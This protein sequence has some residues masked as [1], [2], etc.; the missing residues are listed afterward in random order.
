MKSTALNWLFPLA[1]ML[2]GCATLISSDEQSV[3]VTTNCQSRKIS[4]ICVA[5]NDKGTWRFETP[6]QVV[7]KKS[8]SNLMITCQGGLLGDS[9]QFSTSVLGLPIFGN[10]LIGGGMGALVDAGSPKIYEYPST[11]NVEPAMCKFVDMK[12]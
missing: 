9:G 7:I 8:A 1:I 4:T 12:P 6:A 2:S 10:I 11:I 3:E 5:R